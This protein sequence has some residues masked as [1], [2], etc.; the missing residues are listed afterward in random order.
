MGI[1]GGI[2]ERVAPWSLRIVCVCTGHG[3]TS[4]DTSGGR[5]SA[6]SDSSVAWLVLIGHVTDSTLRHLRGDRSMLVA[7]RQIDAG[8]RGTKSH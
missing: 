4:E 5:G 1:T 3:I 7:A 6:N 2:I 8:W